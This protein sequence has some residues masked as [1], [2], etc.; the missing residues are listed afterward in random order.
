MCLQVGKMTEENEK[1][2]EDSGEEETKVWK[3]FYVLWRKIVK[4]VIPAITKNQIIWS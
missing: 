4:Y 2:P 1:D 3:I